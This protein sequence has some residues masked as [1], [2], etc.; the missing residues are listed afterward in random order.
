MPFFLNIDSHIE[1]FFLATRSPW[2]VDFFSAIAWLGEWKLVIFL[3]I[4]AVAL[5]R[6]KG[7]KEYI[8]SFLITVIGAEISGQLAK[9]IFHRTRPVGGLEAE[10]TF[11]FPS[12]HALIAVA[13]YGF[14]I[15]FCWREAKNREQKYFHPHTNDASS[16]NIKTEEL[17]NIEDKSLQYSRR[18]PVG[19]GVYLSAGMI[20]ILLIGL[21]RLY[22]GAHYFSDVIGGYILGAIWLAIGIYIH[23]K[24]LNKPQ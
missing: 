6:L 18:K 17:K 19:V 15:Y 24:N 9:I 8:L 23:Q 10:N 2:G 7:K 3:V 14:L 22:L 20:L 12:G 16:E 4:L 5:F 13:F 1:N 11:S 21:S